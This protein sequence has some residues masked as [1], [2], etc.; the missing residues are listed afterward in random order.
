M[1]AVIEV[2]WVSESSSTKPCTELSTFP[3]GPGAERVE[4]KLCP[5]REK[6]AAQGFYQQ[7]KCFDK[8]PTQT[9]HC[10]VWAGH[11]I[12]C[13]P[14]PVLTS[15]HVAQHLSIFQC[16]APFPGAFVLQKE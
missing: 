8:H 2:L 5:R 14:A 7:L 4:A 9:T 11:P 3:G 1:P 6:A 12:T 15:S 16:T 10:A 13:S